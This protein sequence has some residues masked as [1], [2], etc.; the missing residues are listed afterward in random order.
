MP[1]SQHRN[2]ISAVITWFLPTWLELALYIFICLF[3][4]FISNLGVVR[5]I[6]YASGDFNPV[7]AG[8]DILTNLLEHFVGERVAGSLS[9]AIFWGLVGLF[10]N[11]VWWVASNFSTE[12]NNDL[13][14]SNYVHPRNYDPK[15]QLHEFITRTIFRSAV[16]LLFLFYINYALRSVLPHL[17]THYHDVLSNWS[18]TRDIGGLLS[19]IGAQILM[20]HAFIV[21]TRLLLLKKQ[22]F[23]V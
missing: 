5:E 13:V 20:M 16:A 6:L 17:T 1:Q 22:I 15:S 10:V 18:V 12:L 3:T 2:R 7:R 19:S 4:I 14:F 23:S 11:A 8:I 9:L 21:L